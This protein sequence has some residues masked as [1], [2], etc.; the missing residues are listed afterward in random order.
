MPTRLLRALFPFL[1]EKFHTMR[2][3][4]ILPCL[5]VGAGALGFGLRRWQLISG[6]DPDTQLFA[7]GH[8]AAVLLALLTAGLVLAAPLLLRGIKVP[9]D[10]APPFRCPSPAYMA[11]MAASA[12]LLLGSGVL[13]LLE[14]MEELA[15]WR[16]DPTARVITYPAAV[17]LCALLAF[18]AGPSLLLLAKGAGRG[19]P[20]P[21]CSLWVLFSPVAALVWLFSVHLAHSTDPILMNYGFSLAAAIFLTLAHYDTA[22]FFHGRPHPFRAAFCALLGVFFGLVSLA[23]GPSPFQ[24][25]L[26]AAFTLSALA[27]LWSLLRTAFGPPWPRELLEGRMPLGAQD[28]QEEEPD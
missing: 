16:M 27:G 17:T 20:H 11:M 28:D 19:E 2:K 5:A 21:S 22:A 18:A 4:L 8:P 26:T 6:Y 10:A 7:A 25:A 15:L 14:G 9:E 1:K 3:A 12:L 23:D 13:G 24:A